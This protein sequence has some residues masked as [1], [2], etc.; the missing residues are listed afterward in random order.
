MWINVPKIIPKES[1]KPMAKF[2]TGSVP[3]A[4]TDPVK[5]G[6]VISDIRIVAN[7]KFLSRK[8]GCQEIL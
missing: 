8:P 5:L 7:K 6:F 1:Q 3:G 2:M 4:V